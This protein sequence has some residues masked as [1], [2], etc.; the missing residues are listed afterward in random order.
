[1]A[2]P[3]GDKIRVV[4][5]DYTAEEETSITLKV[6]DR[7]ELIEDNDPDWAYVREIS[8]GKEGYFP[9]SFLDVAGDAVAAPAVAAA[10]APEPAAAP[11]GGNF[12]TVN[13]DYVAEEETSITLKVGD[14]VE[15]IDDS[16]PDWAYVREVSTGKEG[17][18]PLSFLD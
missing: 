17:Y 11:A 10:P 7:V 14:K 9:L 13:A 4:N 5:C 3:S 16:D 8:T 12:R 18:F 15:V 1:M 2:A 6:G